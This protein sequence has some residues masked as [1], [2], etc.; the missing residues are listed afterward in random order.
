MCCN[1]ENKVTRLYM[2]GKGDYSVSYVLNQVSVG[3]HVVIIDDGGSVGGGFV[4]YANRESVSF[5]GFQGYVVRLTKVD[6]SWVAQHF[7]SILA[8]L[9]GERLTVNAVYVNHPTF[10]G[11]VA[12]S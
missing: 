5:E 12:T 2:E 8:G 6:T 1:V 10:L 11:L 3:D 4:I 7:L 9:A